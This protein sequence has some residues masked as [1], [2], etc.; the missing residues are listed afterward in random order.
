[1]MAAAVGLRVTPINFGE[2]SLADHTGRPSQEI[3]E[4]RFDVHSVDQMMLQAIDLL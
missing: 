1:M 3:A 2:P 4:R